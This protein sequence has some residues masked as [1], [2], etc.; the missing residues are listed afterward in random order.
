[1]EISFLPRIK[2]VNISMSHP[3]YLPE[4]IGC[5]LE[6][7]SFSNE[8]TE[9]LLFEAETRLRS[10]ESAVSKNSALLP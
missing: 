7:N 1:M 3:S 6:E 5:S 4:N 10:Q 8:R 9:Q 2:V